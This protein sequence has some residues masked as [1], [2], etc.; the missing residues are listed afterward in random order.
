MRQLLQTGLGILLINSLA[1]LVALEKT[2]NK[3]DNSCIL[4][5]FFLTDIRSFFN[6][7]RRV[8]RERVCMS[9]IRT[10][11]LPYDFLKI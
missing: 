9:L 6:E 10:D 1:Q 5:V 7:I 4:S 11:L 2:S 8:W 3:N